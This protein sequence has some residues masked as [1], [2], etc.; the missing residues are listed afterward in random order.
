MELQNDNYSYDVGKFEE[1]LLTD[2]AK[3]AGLECGYMEF[4]IKIN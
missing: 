1:G 2:N 4:K 3:K